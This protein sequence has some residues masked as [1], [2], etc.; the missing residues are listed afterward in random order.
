MFRDAAVWMIVGLML[1]GGDGL[2]G[3]NHSFISQIWPEGK[4][5]A[6]SFFNHMDYKLLCDSDPRRTRCWIRMTVAGH[7]ERVHVLHQVQNS[8]WTGPSERPSS[9]CKIL[10]ESKVIDVVL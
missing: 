10:R 1:M 5:M 6:L 3:R 2:F 9:Q 7:D 4:S 8:T